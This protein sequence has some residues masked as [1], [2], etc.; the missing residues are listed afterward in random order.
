MCSENQATSG[1]C[2][3]ELLG[4]FDCTCPQKI[5]LCPSPGVQ[6]GIRTPVLDAECYFSLHGS[7]DYVHSLWAEGCDKHTLTCDLVRS[8]ALLD[9]CCNDVDRRQRI[10]RCDRQLLLYNMRVPGTGTSIL[11]CHALTRSTHWSHWGHT[12]CPALATAS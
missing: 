9:I 5:L 3:K 4:C 1:I 8:S 12:K 7:A 6:S 2:R 10:R 11:S